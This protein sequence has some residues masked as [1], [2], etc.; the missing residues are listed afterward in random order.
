MTVSARDAALLGT[1]DPAAS[2]VTG[3]YS[4]VKGDAGMKRTLESLREEKAEM[5]AS[6]E[7]AIRT[8]DAELIKEIREEIAKIDRMISNS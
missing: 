6:L 7:R 1:F 8:K 4:L 5:Q 2:P 3:G